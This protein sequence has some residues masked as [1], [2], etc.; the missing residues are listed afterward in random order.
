MRIKSIEEL[1]IKE[2][3]SAI[4]IG[5]KLNQTELATKLKTSQS[6]VS[7]WEFGAVEPGL[8]D[9]HQIKELYKTLPDDKKYKE[10]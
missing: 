10:E 9:A 8:I 1:T 7:R 6:N 3:I 4:R 5:Y 2:M